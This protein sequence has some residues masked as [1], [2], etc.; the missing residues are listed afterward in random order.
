MFSDPRRKGPMRVRDRRGNRGTSV[1]DPRSSFKLKR[2][3]PH[4]YK[5]DTLHS[6]IYSFSLT[7]SNKMQNHIQQ[8]RILTLKKIYFRILILKLNS[9]KNYLLFHWFNQFD[10]VDWYSKLHFTDLISLT[11]ST[12]T[13]NYF[14]LFESVRILLM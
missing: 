14:L 6:K 7:S 10:R 11:E 4:F 13:V 8:N 5:K 12:D 3:L 2:R 1:R 9:V